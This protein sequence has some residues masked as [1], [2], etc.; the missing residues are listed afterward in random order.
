M[1]YAEVMGTNATYQQKSDICGKEF[2]LTSW[3]EGVLW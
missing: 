3:R 1:T 2:K